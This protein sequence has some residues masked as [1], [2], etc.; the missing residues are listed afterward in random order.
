VPGGRYIVSSPVVLTMLGGFEVRSGGRTI[1]LP[2]SVERVVAYVALHYGPATRPHVAGTLWFDTP[3][4]RAMASLRSAL[5]RLH[6]P[7]LH[8]IE[9]RGDQ[10]SLSAEV[11]VDFIELSMAARGWLG[12]AAISDI[13]QL[14]QLSTGGE[15]LSDWY[16][17]WVSV[18][19]ERFRHETRRFGPVRACC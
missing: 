11:R 8:L 15:L 17:D 4:E 1:T 18:E 10:L 13:G 7:G 12:G 6:R 9:T 5:W 14:D 19:R 16:D 2:P 3:E